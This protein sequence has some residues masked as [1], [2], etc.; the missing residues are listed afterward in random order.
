MKVSEAETDIND[1][2]NMVCY[3]PEVGHVTGEFKKQAGED[4]DEDVT[5]WCKV[6]RSSGLGLPPS[7]DK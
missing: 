5:G 1:S 4:G 7:V 6:K 2:F 3:D